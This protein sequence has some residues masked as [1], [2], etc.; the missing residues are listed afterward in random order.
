[1]SIM[2]NIKKEKGVED[3]QSKLLWILWF[4][5]LWFMGFSIDQCH[6]TVLLTVLVHEKVLS[7]CS[8]AGQ[9]L[10]LSLA[11]ACSVRWQPDLGPATCQAVLGEG[12]QSRSPGAQHP[13]SEVRC[14]Q[15]TWHT[16]LSLLVVPLH[17]PNSDKHPLADCMIT[18][19]V[20]IL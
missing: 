6:K 17:S 7:L 10:L 20:G 8:C 15:R 9:A 16:H 11:Q 4:F 2:G 5:P 1:M 18:H 13:A 3:I 12:C 14:Y 19:Q